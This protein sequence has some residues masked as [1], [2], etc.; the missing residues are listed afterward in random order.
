MNSSV[1]FGSA[2]L[3]KAVSLADLQSSLI[4]TYTP[5]LLQGSS[6]DTFKLSGSD[7]KDYEFKLSESSNYKQ[8]TTST[9]LF[10]H[11]D[12]DKFF[13][14]GKL[15]KGEGEIK[16]DKFGK[17][18]LDKLKLEFTPVD[19][20]RFNQQYDWYRSFSDEKPKILI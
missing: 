3:Y 11:D 5:F 19:S 18:N 8:G 17:D 14:S 6:E 10:T 16:A 15:Y 2:F 13:D 4:R 9:V 12:N 20:E 1:N 7:Y